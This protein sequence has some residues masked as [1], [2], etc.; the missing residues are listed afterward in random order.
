MAVPPPLRWGILPPATIAATFVHV[1]RAT[2]PDGIITAVASRDVARAAAFI[3]EHLSPPP[4]G[5]G[6]PPVAAVGGYEA[7]LGRPDVDAVYVPLPTAL[8]VDWS[9]RAVRAGKHVLVD[10]PFSSAAGVRAMADAAAAAGVVFL[11]G[12][13]WPHAPWAVAARAAVASGRLGRLRRIVASFTAPIMVAGN[14]RGDPA[15]E[16]HG[17]LGDLGWYCARVATHT[18]GAAAAADIVSAYGVGEWA[19]DGD[20]RVLL[21]AVAVVAFRN[22]TTLSF[23]VDFSGG[24]RQRFELVGDTA[25]LAIDDFVIPPA[26]TPSFEALRPAGAA[27]VDHPYT[28]TTT[29]AVAPPREGNGADEPPAVGGQPRALRLVYPHVETVT[30]SGGGRNQPTH[31]VTAFTAAVRAGAG[32][33]ADAARWAAEAVATQRILDLLFESIGQGRPVYPGKE[34]A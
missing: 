18:L 5:D 30:V 32:G 27:S 26:S 8:A 9:V 11:D 4:G 7:L 24:L 22:G 10:K 13:H 6:S 14:I 17:A 28:R 20:G 1:I 34:D 33:A 16:P 21:S 23:D 2:A 19:G 29:A 15:L 12:T 3:D 25:S 31:M